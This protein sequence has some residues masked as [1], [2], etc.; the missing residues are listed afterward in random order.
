M[1]KW[2]QFVLNFGV[3]FYEPTLYSQI[4]TNFVVFTK[5][6]FRK[7]LK[8]FVM[9][10]KELLF[11][12]ES[13]APLSL[14]E[15]YD[16]A[17]LLVGNPEDE[18]TNV[19]V[20]LDTTEAVIDEAILK[21]CNV[22]V[23]HHPIIFKGLKKITGRN[24]IEKTI[25]KAIKN[26]IAIYVSHTNLDN[27]KGGVNFKIAEKLQLKNPQILQPKIETLLKLVVFVPTERTGNLLDALYAAGAGKIGN[28]SNCSFRTEGTGSFKPN[29]AAN[30]F[31]GKAGQQEE[32][33]ENRVE[34]LVPFY[35][36]N[37][38]LAAMRNA[39]PYEEIA[40]FLSPL[41]NE[42]QDIGSG[43]IG[44][45]EKP[46][47]SLD[48][49]AFLKNAMQLKVIRHTAITS[50]FISKIALCGGSGGFLLDNAIAQKADIFITADYKYHE[51][52]DANNKL[53]IADIGHYESE[54]FT[55]E[56]LQ[57]IICQKF[58]NFATYLSV[59]ETNPV[60]YF[61]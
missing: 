13:L 25:I 2:I 58:T 43:V 10:I 50:D 30:P 35:L 1:T 23:A 45:L 53:I 7:L 34:V 48:F 27:V 46:M 19:L 47:P 57:D 24:Y 60:N 59:V 49:F 18:I 5:T 3:F 44:Y 9:K 6:I 14:Q 26:D 61:Y 37:K 22:I 52:F 16:N 54:Q 36:K 38:I 17:G 8:N 11:Y 40:Y 31:L 21:G 51:F 20:T 39:H 56:L 4:K 41:E 28:Y 33:T 29:A 15:S 32:V 12:I 42:N 55:K